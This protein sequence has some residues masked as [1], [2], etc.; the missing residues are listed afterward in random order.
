[1]SEQIVLAIKAQD[2]EIKRLT[3]EVNR[4]KGSLGGIPNIAKL[5]AGAL[6][7]IGLVRLTQSVIGTIRQFEDL[8]AN[9]VTIEGDAERA[10]KS[11]G[12]I[13]EFTA[14]TPFQLQDVTQAFITF[15]NAGLVPTADFMTNIGNIAA[16]MNRRIDDVARAVFNATTGEFEML[17]QLG[18]K[19]KTEGDKLTVNFRGTATTI[20]N[21]GR[22]IVELINE[23]GRTE[24][25]GG[26]ERSSQTLTGAI[27]NLKDNFAILADEIGQGGLNE[28]LQI[29]T[30]D[31]IALSGEQKDLAH[32]LGREL[33]DAIL[34]VRDNFQLLKAAMIGLGVVGLIIQIGKLSTGLVALQK[35]VLLVNAAMRANPILFAVGAV[36]AGVT[37]FK[38]E[39]AELVG[40]T[41]EQEKA[42]IGQNGALHEGIEAT[43]KST[44]SL[45]E[46]TANRKDNTKEIEQAK[47]AQERLAAA[48]KKRIQEILRLNETELQKL[49]RKQN[50]EMKLIKDALKQGTIDHEIAQKARF[51]LEKFYSD[52]ARAIRDQ[53]R[54]DD[55]AKERK[56]A[57]ERERTRRAGVEAFIEGRYREAD[58]TEVTEREKTEVMVSQG[59]KTLDLLAQENKKFFQLQKAVKIASA[60]QNTYEGASKA[61]AQGGFFGFAMAALV[62]AAG[63]AQVAAIRRENYPERRMGGP[64]TAGDPFI[65]GEA[66]KELFIPQSSGTI[67]PN[68]RMGGAVTLNFNISAIDTSDFDDLL[69]TR[70]DMIVGLVNRALRERGMRAITA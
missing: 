12:L 63:L 59:K 33:G 56:A 11:F 39:I 20:K 36:A 52:K 3:G 54:Q 2:R 47:R 8:R 64:V 57:Q 10:A 68:D 29:I 38:D 66:G 40:V 50:E 67:V 61:F 16:G 34:F 62:I 55:L 70:Q 35:A 24:L 43:Q 51:E 65:V 30:R 18:I 6:G 25:A 44:E 14:G 37:F 48:Q 53:A 7:A 19:V 21:D 22:E 23:I 42:Q 13:Q 49:A 69:M 17:K 46:N 31:I 28:A 27:S 4:L 32:A 41:K 58:I 45:F 15:R 9:L 5:A 26:I 1:M 60:I